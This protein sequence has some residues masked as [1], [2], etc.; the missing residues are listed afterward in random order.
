MFM[1]LGF[2]MPLAMPPHPSLLDKIQRGEVSKPIFMTEPDFYRNR[3]INQAED[4]IFQP[5]AGLAN[6]NV[7]AVLVEFS[8]QPGGPTQ[9]T[10]DNLLFGQTYYPGPS[11]REFYN[12]ASYGNLNLV[13]VN[14]PST[15]G[16]LGLPHNRRYYTTAGG[17]FTYGMGTYPNNSQGLCEDLLTILDPFV[18]FAN[19]DN[20]GD[21]YVDGIIII[22]SG[23]GAELSGDTLDIWSHKWEITPQWLDGVWVKNYCVDPEYRYFLGDGTVGV[24]AH[25]F[26]HILGL[27]DLYDYGNDSYGLGYWSLMAYGG[28]NGDLGAPDT[29][30]GSSPAFLDA[31]SR[32]RLGFVTPTNVACYA[33]NV[34]FP[35]V[36]D[37]AKVYHLWTN[38]S[39]SSPEYFLVENRQYVFTDTALDAHGLLIYHIDDTQTNNN[40]QWWPGQPAANHY[41]VAVEQADA[42]WHLEHAVNGM[43]I[44]DPFR[45]GLNNTFNNASSPSSQDYYGGNTLV[46]ITNI[47]TSAYIM[48]ADMDVGA[49]VAPDTP[50]LIWP[51]DGYVTG[52][53]L[54]TLTCENVLCASKYHIQIDDDPLFGSPLYEDNNLAYNYVQF[55]FYGHPDGQYYW[56]ARAGNTAGWSGWSETRGFFM[57]RVAPSGSVASSPDTVY[58]SSFIVSW[59][60]GYDPPPSGGICSYLVYADTGAGPWI[61][62]LSDVDFLSAEFAGADSGKTY[63]FQARARD[64]ALNM[65]TENLIPECSTYVADVEHAYA[66]LAGDANMANETVELGNPLTGPWRVGGDVTFLVNFFDLSSGNQ[67]CL[68]HN[69]NNT[70]NYP[71]G[72]QNGYY[73]AS[74]DATGE[75]FVAGND[76]TRLVNYFASVPDNPIRWYG[77]DKP[78]PENY[79]PPLWLVNR[80]A[81]GFQPVPPL[82]ELPAGWPNCQIQPEPAQVMP[83]ESS[84]R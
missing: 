25:E 71:G 18:N 9:V 47:S 6:W 42:A 38:G 39:T 73:F 29:L 8:D 1:A 64:C 16:W 58:S 33:S 69:P 36:E 13:T 46:S 31:W 14:Y 7:L 49:T 24:F 15:Y 22:H 19:Y 62:W 43:D 50:A 79:Y 32:V 2:S 48:L 78:D 4:P 28:W 65:E 21:S 30:S 82:E 55:T 72:P 23:R 63:Y 81:P 56:R 41:W 17:M 40:N 60:A 5:G 84:S 11:L 10:F 54:V 59:T 51:D 74:G 75:G 68:M 20:N 67:P 80:G 83:S 37:S 27:P 45:A 57:D 70:D 34:H 44:F 26:G 12:R 3:G 76:V 53:Q 77:W 35:A 66:Y 61:L 52:Y